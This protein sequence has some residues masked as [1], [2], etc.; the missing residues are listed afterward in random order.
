MRKKK[1]KYLVTEKTI[2]QTFEIHTGLHVC[3][4][5]KHMTKGSRPMTHAAG[6]VS[7][8][9]IRVLDMDTITCSV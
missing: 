8:L 9:T 4:E 2:D 1:N 5:R 3:V 6:P 7:I